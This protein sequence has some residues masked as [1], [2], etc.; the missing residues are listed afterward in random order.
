[1]WVIDHR[2][3]VR[4]PSELPRLLG[5]SLGAGKLANYALENF[6]FIIVGTS[7]CRTYVRLRPRFVPRDTLTALWFW[8]HENIE[9]GC[10]VNWLAGDTWRDEVTF[11]FS[12]TM[13]LIEALCEAS[14]PRRQDPS[15]RL[16][17]RPLETPRWASHADLEQVGDLVC[18]ATGDVSVRQELSVQF[19]G[20]W[21]LSELDTSSGQVTIRGMGEG[22]PLYDCAW[23]CE[24]LGRSFDEFPDPDYGHFVTES[25]REAFTS[26][27]PI[28]DEINALINWPRFGPLR[29]RYE[30]MIVP[31]FSGSR[32]LLLSASAVKAHAGVS[33]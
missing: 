28:Y 13:R 33:A 16:K 11:G 32:P 12:P 29:T 20:R 3:V 31:F 23:T 26:G 14:V 2:G 5:S 27:R 9:R 21:T 17:R 1:M 10:S 8:L 19:G 6:G 25:H 24:P 18:R 22:Y 7:R 15:S 4:A 30:R